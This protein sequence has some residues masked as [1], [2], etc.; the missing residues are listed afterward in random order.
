MSEA[1][2]ITAGYLGRL[3]DRK[4]RTGLTVRRD[5]DAFLRS[6]RQQAEHL[7]N[8]LGLN[9]SSTVLDIGC[10][11]GRLAIGILNTIGE[12][13]EY[14]GLDVARSAID[15][16]EHNISDRHPAFRFH[17]VDV[18]NKRYNPTGERI[19]R[20]KFRLPVN[21]GSCDIVVMSSLLSHLPGSHARAY[22]GEA[23]RAVKSGGWI[24]ATGYVVDDPHLTAIENPEEWR[25][26]SIPEWKGPLHCV[27][28]GWSY[29]KGLLVSAGLD[30]VNP[31]SPD[32]PVGFGDLPIL[33][34]DQRAF[35]LQCKRVQ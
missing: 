18:H 21:S 8:V 13:R 6:G 11:V 20:A 35:Y 12:V 9:P 34:D 17:H 28:Y 27:L 10:G 32:R 26:D 15:W 1:T 3:P 7:R 24:Y 2:A 31:A 14:L 16:C 5:D 29:F 25:P 33:Q 19:S 23:A 4:T 30:L 22:L